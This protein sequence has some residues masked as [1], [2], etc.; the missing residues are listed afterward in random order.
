MR[1]KSTITDCILQPGLAIM[2]E[3]HIQIFVDIM[4]GKALYMG[5]FNK[6]P[7]TN[8]LMFKEE[9]QRERVS[10]QFRGRAE[11]TAFFS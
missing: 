5:F 8:F 9:Q 3:T 6:L 11:R 2:N 7:F 10:I 1:A 4:V